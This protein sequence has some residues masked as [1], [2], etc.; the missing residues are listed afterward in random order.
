MTV[1][2]LGM[3]VEGLAD[4]GGGSGACGHTLIRLALRA[5][6][7]RLRGDRLF[8]HQGRRKSGSHSGDNTRRIRCSMAFSLDGRMCPKGG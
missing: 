3:M 2:G 7:P 5:I 4:D 6:H 1:E 8:S